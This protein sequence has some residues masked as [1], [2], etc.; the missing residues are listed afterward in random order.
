M[1]KF[2]CIAIREVAFQIR[3]LVKFEKHFLNSTK[4]TQNS[5]LNT[6]LG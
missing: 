4:D 2:L 3:V 6:L 5:L 1:C